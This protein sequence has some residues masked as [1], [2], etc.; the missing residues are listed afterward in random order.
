MLSVLRFQKCPTDSVLP[1]HPLDEK[2][3]SLWFLVLLKTDVCRRHSSS[4]QTERKIRSNRTQRS[5]SV[6]AISKLQ[7]IRIQTLFILGE[8]RTIPLK[9]RITRLHSSIPIT[10]CFHQWQAVYR[11]EQLEHNISIFRQLLWISSSL[12][13]KRKRL[14]ETA[15]VQ[16]LDKI[17]SDQTLGLY[18]MI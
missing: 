14:L 15:A 10:S 1:V 12:L 9:T 16:V 4:Q 11:M 17:Q 8:V 3:C 7:Q 5:R 13:Q 6:F 18:R 2:K